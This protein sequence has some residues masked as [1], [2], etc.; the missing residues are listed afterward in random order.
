MV[1]RYL[2][3]IKKVEKALYDIRLNNNYPNPFNMNTVIS[4]SVLKAQRIELI[5]YN[6]LGQ[7]VKILVNKQMSAGNYQINFDGS[8]LSSGVYFCLLKND[9]IFQ[10]KKMLLLK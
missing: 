9:N 10:V 1:L 4:Y 7:L 2:I 5:I 6:A 8:N 3:K